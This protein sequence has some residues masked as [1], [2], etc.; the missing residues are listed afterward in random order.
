MVVL[1]NLRNYVLDRRSFTNFVN[2]LSSP[3]A[4][5]LGRLTQT[6]PLFRLTGARKGAMLPNKSVERRPDMGKAKKMDLQ[7]LRNLLENCLNNQVNLTFFLP[8]SATR[9]PSWEELTNFAT[10]AYAMAL[11]DVLDA[12]DGDDS[13]IKEVQ[14]DEGR[15]FFRLEDK[16][17]LL[18]RLNEFDQE[19]ADEKKVK[20]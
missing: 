1:I 2:K 16:E 17:E 15:I 10:E 3:A 18:K 19:P 9:N 12:M 8:D 4:S 13:A 6:R 5:L 14:S 20:E 7:I 11:T